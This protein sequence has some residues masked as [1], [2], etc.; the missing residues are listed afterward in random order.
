[1]SAPR[2]FKQYDSS[3]EKQVFFGDE[4]SL[5]IAQTILKLLKE[6]GHT[7]QFYFELSAENA[8]I[9]QLMGIDNSLVLPK[10]ISQE[11]IASSLPIFCHEQWRHVNFLLTG[12]ASSLQQFRKVIRQQ[13]QAI[14]NKIYSKG[15]WQPGKTAL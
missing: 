4:T 13:E 15:Y 14:A 8:D 12:N 5:G 2:G 3:I 1:M 9:P 6:N 11:Q 7:Y 10:G